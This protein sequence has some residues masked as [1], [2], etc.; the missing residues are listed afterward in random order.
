MYRIFRKINIHHC[1]ISLLI[2]FSFSNILGIPI[3]KL[4]FLPYPFENTIIEIIQ[5]IILLITLSI[6]MKSKKL[7]IKASNN[8]TYYFKFILIIFL[9]Y[10]ENSFFTKGLSSFFNKTN[11]QGEINF[12]NLDVI[13]NLAIS[14]IYIYGL[15]AY[16]NLTYSGL[17]FLV[18][19]GIMGFSSFISKSRNIVFFSFDRKFS[20]YSLFCFIELSISFILS[21]FVNSKVDLISWE[22][23]ELFLYILFLV[24]IKYKANKYQLKRN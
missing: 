4:E 20:F 8:L 9:I 17:L 15:D 22:Q 16:F 7:F 18:F 11:G 12:H 23:T 10:E 14:K 3:T 1:L 13:H 2:F 21:Q 6:Y 24:D 5:T 19:L